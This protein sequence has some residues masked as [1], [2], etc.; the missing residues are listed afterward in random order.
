MRIGEL[1]ALVGVS[2]RTVRHYHHLG[3]LPEPLRR[4]LRGPL[5]ADDHR[6][7]RHPAPRGDRRGTA[8]PLRHVLRPPRP[9]SSD[10]LGAA[11]ARLQ[12]ERHDHRGGPAAQRG[13][14]LPDQRGR[15]AGRA[16]HRGPSPRRPCRGHHDPLLHRH[17]RGAAERPAALPAPQRSLIPTRPVRIRRRAVPRRHASLSSSVRSGQILY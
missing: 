9:P 15:R 8:C 17:P 10:L 1:A 12:R 6:G 11:V 16:G 14:V 4:R 7:L 13:G 5:R 2:T 3:L